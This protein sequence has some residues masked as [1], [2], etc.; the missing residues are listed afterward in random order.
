MF[1]KKAPVKKQTTQIKESDKHS[2]LLYEKNH[3]YDVDISLVIPNPM[4][5]RKKFDDVAANYNVKGCWILVK[6]QI[7]VCRVHAFS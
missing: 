2:S 7:D 5:P 3:I 4:Q 6:E 1:N